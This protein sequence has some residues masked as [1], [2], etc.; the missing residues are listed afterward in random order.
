LI[1][2][3]ARL[4]ALCNAEN[5]RGRRTPS[6]DVLIDEE[7]FRIATFKAKSFTARGAKAEALI[8]MIVRFDRTPL[9]RLAASLAEDILSDGG[10]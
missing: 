5:E 1:A 10:S 3:C 8:N 6:T 2:A 4:K 7:V 9:S